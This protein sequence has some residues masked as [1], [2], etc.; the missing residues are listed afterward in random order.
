VVGQADTEGAAG[1]GRLG[2]AQDPTL[3][4][5]G[6]VMISLHL[7]DGYCRQSSFAMNLSHYQVP[8]QPHP[9]DIAVQRVFV[10][11]LCPGSATGRGAVDVVAAA[12]HLSTG[13]A[14]RLT[15]AGSGQ[16]VV[17][18]CLALSAT[19]VA[20]PEGLRPGGAR[21]AESATPVGRA[22]RHYIQTVTL[23]VTMR[24]P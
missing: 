11:V 2:P 5:I 19:A 15:A 20:G 9:I 18:G 4:V 13:P 10:T 17:S 1:C 7:P 21:S 12:G 14:P 22:V 8:G 24:P 6:Q 3:V 23:I 16:F